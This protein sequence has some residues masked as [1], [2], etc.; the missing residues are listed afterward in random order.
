MGGVEKINWFQKENLRLV[1][2]ALPFVF[3]VM[4]WNELP[5]RVPLH[6][7]LNGEADGYGSKWALLGIAGLNLLLFGLFLVLPH[8]DPK[9]KNYSNSPNGSSLI[10]VIIHLFI[11]Y[12][13]FIVAFMALGYQ[14]QINLTVMYGLI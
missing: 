2:I 6:W 1:I 8:L 5:A 13:F 9:G 7:N 14:L 11:T 12:L 4:F 3:L 10:Q